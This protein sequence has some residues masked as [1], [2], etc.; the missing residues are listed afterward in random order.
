M[1]DREELLSSFVR[2]LDQAEWVAVDTEADSLHAYPEKLC[3]MQLS[4]PSNDVLVDP[5]AGMEMGEFFSSLR[6]K[7][8]I[9]HGADYDVR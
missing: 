1:I 9:M 8:L 6:A 2:D 7:T 5:L 4:I 3:L